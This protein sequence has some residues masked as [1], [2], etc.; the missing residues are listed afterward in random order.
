M[1]KKLIGQ[2]LRTLRGTRSREEVAVACEVSAQAI[3]MYET[4][5]RI[6][7]DSK[8]IKIAEYFGIPVGELFY[9]E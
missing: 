2:R 1:D 4:G 3:C 8:K 9:G 7:N 5:R 6:P